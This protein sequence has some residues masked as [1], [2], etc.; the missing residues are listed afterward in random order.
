MNWVSFFILFPIFIYLNISFFVDFNNQNIS[1][2]VLLILPLSLLI[3][4]WLF[5]KIKF[6][7]FI[8]RYAYVCLI[9]SFVLFVSAVKSVSLIQSLPETIKLLTILLIPILL[10][11]VQVKNFLKHFVYLLTL[12]STLVS[13]VFILRPLVFPNF[14]ASDS[15]L[16]ITVGHGQI[17]GLLIIVIPLVVG[18]LI[19]TRSKRFR[20]VYSVELM[21]L[22]VA[23]ILSL[24]RGALLIVSSLPILL[25]I[26]RSQPKPLRS[27]VILII[28]VVA[29]LMLVIFA[30][31]QEISGVTSIGIRSLNTLTRQPL[32]FNTRIQY[33]TKAISIWRSHV[34]FG[35]GLGTYTYYPDSVSSPIAASTYVHNFYLQLL[36]ETGLVS[37]LIFLLL[38]GY[39]LYYS[40]QETFRHKDIFR[41]TIF[42]AVIYSVLYS[43]F[44]LNL[45]QPVLLM[46]ILCLI[47]F[48]GRSSDESPSRSFVLP[49]L[50]FLTIGLSTAFLFWSLLFK[51]ILIN[52]QGFQE[53]VSRQ[54]PSFIN[55]W[56]LTDFGNGNK[57]ISL[58]RHYFNVGDYSQSIRRLIDAAHAPFNRHHDFDTMMRLSE[59]DFSRLSTHDLINVSYLLNYLYHYYDQGFQKA[60]PWDQQAPLFALA[61]KLYLDPRSVNIE[62]D[63]KRLIFW[64]IEGELSKDTQDWPF[65]SQVLNNPH[66]SQDPDF[67]T[68]RHAVD[69][70]N[71]DRV[72]SEE[73]ISISD[74][75]AQFTPAHPLFRL[76]HPLAGYLKGRLSDFYFLERRFPESIRIL[77]QAITLDR[78]SGSLRLRLIHRLQVLGEAEAARSEL[79]RCQS[80]V[81]PDCANWLAETY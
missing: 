17:A 67:A 60:G 48:L 62:I 26:F 27:L 81:S 1:N 51:H 53:Q 3:Q 15:F 78:Y 11:L 47:V 58:S 2:L 34:W 52:S 63:Q 56:N 31:H 61:K 64:V 33:F 46:I 20:V 68:L 7:K 50:I 24:S 55:L 54:D 25:V 73:L 76:Y 66:F 28:P 39:L 57:D 36:A 41:L 9:L 49:I 21:I 69:L 12:S 18:L 13:L 29:V 35:Q 43:L 70:L 45:N 65:L 8:L 79:S 30:Y 14:N 6:T 5:H 38:L 22:V 74:T 4:V 44:D 10:S 80:E 37:F 71:L 72:S 75:L 23:L 42:I 77:E 16:G 59:I 40:Y 19:S 32:N